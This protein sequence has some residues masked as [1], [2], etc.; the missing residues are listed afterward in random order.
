MR[1]MD[2]QTF[3]RQ[4]AL[5]QPTYVPSDQVKSQLAQ[6]DLI[7]TAGPTGVG[8]T[9]I[10]EHSGIPYITSDVTREPRKNEQNGVDY[11]FRTD[12][13]KLM[14]EIENGEYVQYIVHPNG[15]FYGT[16]ASSYP[17]T[18]PCT[19]AIVTS[20]I[21]LFF[22]LGFRRV[23]LVYILPPS[24]EEWVVRTK[25]HKDHDL[26]VRLIE[27]KRSLEEAL[28]D[29]RYKYV[30][31]DDL[32][33][34]RDAFLAIVRGGEVDPAA[35]TKARELALSLLSQIDTFKPADLVNLL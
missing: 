9:T 35:Q 7:I 32:L 26:S 25:A 3:M 13:D 29:S 17:A 8:K 12:Y 19:I 23:E 4:A 33:D 27:A 31:N 6:V 30:I 21:P 2:K 24:Y 11:V 15:E 20:S 18:G 16:K 14:Q 5:K 22:S 28:S 1:Q 10:M 34:A